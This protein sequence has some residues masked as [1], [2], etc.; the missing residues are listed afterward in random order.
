MS[1]RS[2]ALTTTMPAGRL[3]RPARRI[4]T[5]MFGR[6]VVVWVAALRP[7]AD[8]DPDAA[9]LRGILAPD[10]LRRV[11]SIS[12]VDAR[13]E[14]AAGRLL[15]RR[16]LSRLLG[17]APAAVRLAV[18]PGGRPALVPGPGGRPAFD[19]NLSHSGGHLALAVSRSLRVGVD[20]ER[21]DRN[22]SPDTL[23]TLATLSRRYFTGAEQGLLAA[24]AGTDTYLERWYR[25]WTTK[26]A[27]AKARGVGVRGLTDPLTGHGIRWQRRHLAVAHRCLGSVV[28]LH[29]SVPQSELGSEIL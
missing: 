27:H 25:I 29:P 26:E 14:Y 24:R 22:Q 3:L 19:F 1:P 23:T 9:A 20:I 16:V 17:T 5:A 15:L 10:E 7:D 4:G 18:E 8:P 28:V 2:R 21:L 13:L 12:H 11:A 6:P